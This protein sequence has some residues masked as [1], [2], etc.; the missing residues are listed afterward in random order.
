MAFFVDRCISCRNRWAKG[1]NSFSC[2]ISL[3]LLSPYSLGSL[4]SSS[5]KLMFFDSMLL[6]I[7]NGISCWRFKGLFSF[8]SNI[9]CIKGCPNCFEVREFLNFIKIMRKPRRQFFS[10]RPLLYS[11]GKY[12]TE[13]LESHGLECS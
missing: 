9:I 6:G 10:I 4:S 12:T 5:L 3:M 1:N 2:T 13:L 11:T 7:S 8:Q